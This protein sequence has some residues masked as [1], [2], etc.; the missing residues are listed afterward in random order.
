MAEKLEL[1]FS[2]NPYRLNLAKLTVI[3]DTLSRP[4]AMD[5]MGS[6]ENWLGCHL[7]AHLAIHRYLIE[8]NRPVP[9]FL[10][11]D[12]PTQVYFPSGSAYRELDGSLED[13]EKSDADTKAVEKM[14]ALLFDVCEALFP[15]FQIIVTEH[16]NLPDQKFQDALVE[17]PWRNG[18][19]LIPQDWLV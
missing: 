9:R 17:T 3:A 7:I 12:Q 18:L 5:R 16:A 13:F 19:A 15:N 8:H 1:E 4:I 2:G 10:F 14:F 6:G 11:L